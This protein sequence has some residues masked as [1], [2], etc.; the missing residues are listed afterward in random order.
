MRRIRNILPAARMVSKNSVVE[1]E[2]FVEHF[3][4]LDRF[5][6]HGSHADVLVVA[7]QANRV[8]LRVVRVSPSQHTLSAVEVRGAD[9]ASQAHEH[10]VLSWMFSAAISLIHRDEYTQRER[11]S[12]PGRTTREA[13]RPCV[14]VHVSVF[15][16][17][18]CEDH[19]I[20]S[21]ICYIACR[22]Y[23]AVSCPREG[24]I[25]WF[26]GAIAMILQCAVV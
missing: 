12:A 19:F 22:D 6:V 18:S 17:M 24:G 14:Y 25:R 23:G 21:L 4:A 1:S 7:H 2:L 26:D 3:W 9:E 13:R 10:R 15:L 11:V 8:A 5:L 20:D 16:F